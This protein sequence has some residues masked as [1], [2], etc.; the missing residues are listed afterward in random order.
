MTNTRC[1]QPL[2]V[3]VAIGVGAK[4]MASRAAKLGAAGSGSLFGM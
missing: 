4:R 2:S 1:H 3:A